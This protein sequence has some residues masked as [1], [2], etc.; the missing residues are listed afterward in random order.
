MKHLIVEGLGDKVF[1]EKYCQAIFEVLSEEFIKKESI[2]R[3]QK[4]EKIVKVFNHKILAFE[5]D[6][7]TIKV[8]DILIVETAEGNFFKTNILT[9][10]LDKKKYEELII[11]EKREIAISVELNIKKNQK[12]YILKGVK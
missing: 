2:Y 11:S 9:I 4:I 7:Y 5:I 6:N 12:F 10:E 1:F 3:F 8:G